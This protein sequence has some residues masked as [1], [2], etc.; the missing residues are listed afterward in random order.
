ME[1]IIGT[2]AHGQTVSYDVLVETYDEVKDKPI[3]GEVPKKATTARNL[4]ESAREADRVKYN[5]GS[6]TIQLYNPGDEVRASTT[7]PPSW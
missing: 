3:V 6:T 4:P 7:T 5:Y 2:E 1:Q